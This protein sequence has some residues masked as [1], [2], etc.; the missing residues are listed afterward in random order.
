MVYSS[1]LHGN[2]VEQSLFH[3]PQG[4]DGDET[5]IAENDEE[6]QRSVF[7]GHGTLD[8]GCSVLP[9]P[10][11]EYPQWIS[12]IDACVLESILPEIGPT[13]VP[14]DQWA[15]GWPK[16]RSPTPASE[17]YGFFA[18]TQS[19]D[20]FAFHEPW[21]T[22]SFA[23]Q[24]LLGGGANHSSEE[25]R[26]VCKWCSE[27]FLT[28]QSLEAHAKSEGHRTY[29][30]NEGGC[31]RTFAR[32]DTFVRHMTTHRNSDVHTCRI[33]LQRSKR[34]IFK[35]KDHLYQHMRNRHPSASPTLQN[36][37][38]NQMHI[39]KITLYDGIFWDTPKLIVCKVL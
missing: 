22:L 8:D 30:C 18:N 11:A 4:I 1:S 15:Q 16:E 17:G 3:D 26:Y 37:E 19:V 29:V 24:S 39:T 10:P 27:P 9:E 33:C 31:G 23:P 2:S 35:R 21:S 25:L 34:R 38:C 14:D 13:S 5:S 32:R 7:S 20:N 12:D 36:S 6:W 28:S